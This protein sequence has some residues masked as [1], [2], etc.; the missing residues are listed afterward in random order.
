MAGGLWLAGAGAVQGCDLGCKDRM[1]HICCI[2]TRLASTAALHGLMLHSRAPAVVVPHLSPL[3]SATVY[4]ALYLNEIVAAKEIDIGRSP[5]MQEAFV[6]VSWF[7]VIACPPA[8]APACIAA[9]DAP[10]ACV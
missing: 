2:C 5:A 4:R 6:N 1:W 10:P 9:V 8:A 3:C 7:A